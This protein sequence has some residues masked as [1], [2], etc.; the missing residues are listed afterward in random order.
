MTTVISHTPWRLKASQE[1][2]EVGAGV[3]ADLRDAIDSHLNSYRSVWA[4]LVLRRDLVPQAPWTDAEVRRFE[5]LIADLV[6]RVETAGVSDPERVVL[7]DSVRGVVEVCALA[8]FLDVLLQQPEFVRA[9]LGAVAH[10][11][12]LPWDG[13]PSA[14]ALE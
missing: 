7:P 12:P 14:L 3:D 13:A 9:M 1:T 4:T 8:P 5:G 6:H 2:C 10:A 11:M